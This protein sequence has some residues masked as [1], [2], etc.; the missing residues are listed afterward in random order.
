M[1]GQSFLDAVVAAKREELPYRQQKEPLD[2]LKR[3]IKQIT[4]Q[5]EGRAEQWSL[6]RAILEGPR[7]PLNG[8]K[9]IQVIGEIK[10]AVPG[11]GRLVNDLER[12]GLP[13]AYT[14]S[15][16]TAVAVVTEAKHY[17]GHIDHLL[18][19][20]NILDGYYP[21]GR[22]AI[23][24]RD[25]LFDPYHIWESRAFG[26]D[27]IALLPAI[28]AND[29]LR[30]L[31]ALAAELD[32]ECLLEVRNEVEVQRALDAG[33]TMIGIEN[34]DYETQTS[35]LATTGRL[36]PLIPQGV[37]VV[38]EHGI[39]ERADVERVA[40]WDVHAVLAGEE[41]ISARDVKLKARELMV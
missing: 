26:A 5:K 41:L 18:Q 13:R 33:A 19:T 39:G 17:M 31:T 6:M 30:A 12:Q 14:H 15:G 8:G 2:A 34:L 22:P 23:L 37:V 1:T 3:R 16:V 4:D 28:L 24:R 25:F 11:R 40:D 38:S 21:G 7:G 27:A 9:R 10:K 36:R 32:L 35:D 20:R 29:E